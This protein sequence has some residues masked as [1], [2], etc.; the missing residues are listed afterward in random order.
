[1]HDARLDVSG[2]SRSRFVGY[3]LI[4]AQIDT[5]NAEALDRGLS[6]AQGEAPFLIV[7]GC[8]RGGQSDAGAHVGLPERCQTSSSND[9]DRT[10]FPRHHI[11]LTAQRGQAIPERP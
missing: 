11:G 1:M 2:L 10:A 7:A 9:I 8:A 3:G 5:A 6:N 4:S